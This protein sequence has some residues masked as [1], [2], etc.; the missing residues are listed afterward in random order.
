MIYSTNWIERLN[1][2][3][4]RVLRMRGEMPNPESVLFL[5]GSVAMEKEFKRYKYP[6]TV[7][8]DVEE[9]KRKKEEASSA[10]LH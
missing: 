10:T 1:R 7:F 5:M 4:K 6:V 3:Y 8:R 9:L 2:D